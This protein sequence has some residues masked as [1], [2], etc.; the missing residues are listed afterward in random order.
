MDNF[1]S[2]KHALAHLPENCKAAE[3]NLIFTEK[4][5]LGFQKGEMSESE[6]CE[7]STIF[8]RAT[9]EKTGTVYTENQEDDPYDLIRKAIAV[10]ELLNT[11][12]ALSFAPPRTD[13]EESLFEEKD[14]WEMEGFCRD[15]SLI[16]SVENCSL[17]KSVRRSYVLNS[18]GLETE[19]TNGLYDFSVSVTGM[20]EDNFKSL[21]RSAN[22]LQDIDP[23]AMVETLKA[24][25]LL[26]HGELPIIRLSAGTYDAVLSAEM[27]CNIFQTAWKLFVK[28][29][30]ENRKNG[31]S[32][33]SVVGSEAFSVT[34]TAVCPVT[35]YDFSIDYEGVRGNPVNRIVRNG[36]FLSPLS[37]LEDGESSGNGGREDL[38][39][40]TT[41]T[42]VI[43]IP[44]NLFVES[45]DSDPE[46]LIARMGTGIHLTYSLDEFHST[47]TTNGTFSIP[48][49]GVYY[50]EG[51][52]KGRVQQM[53]VY[54][55]F[56]DLFSRIEA[57]GSDLKIKP[58]MIYQS[59]CYG[60][61]SLLA[62]GLNFS[63]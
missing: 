41:R 48:C 18:Y 8:V 17:T 34:D 57:A 31:F 44:R 38:I 5:T 58:M 46:A 14:I 49:G 28:K 63:M 24:E 55:N 1:D 40:G 23:A 25:D 27:I 45:G 33:G 16:E 53:T 6:Y 47:N 59:Y 22:R 61:P 50:E 11:E 37:T 2:Y 36:T 7:K 19:L 62:R 35:G 13:T 9:G 54:G 39:S 15:V 56:K 43:A 21:I 12:K 3:I 60:G 20:G 32:I 10:S 30:M 26:E 4:T 51:V 52:P 42:A 29:G